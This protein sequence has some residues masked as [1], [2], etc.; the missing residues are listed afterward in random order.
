[1]LRSVLGCTMFKEPSNCSSL[2]IYCFS[3]MMW[4]V[5]A[6]VQVHSWF[7]IC[8]CHHKVSIKGSSCLESHKQ[9]KDIVML[10]KRYLWNYKKLN[11]ILPHHRNLFE[12]TVAL[13]FSLH[14]PAFPY[15]WTVHPMFFATDLLHLSAVNPIWK[16]PYLWRNL[17]ISFNKSNHIA[18]LY[19][20][21]YSQTLLP[22]GFHLQKS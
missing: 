17:N 11:L 8:W 16:K 10:V 6:N 2:T 3:H 9:R 15:A 13:K 14:P 4:I 1:M 19:S 18:F 7:W 22:T 20:W 12:A 5:Q 21:K